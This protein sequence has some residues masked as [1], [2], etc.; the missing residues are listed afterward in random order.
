M[1]GYVV[2]AP[3]FGIVG[4]I[5]AALIYFY[6]KRQPSGTK[7]MIEIS[8]AIHEGAMVFLKKEYKIISIFIVFVFL[9]KVK[10]VN[11]FLIFKFFHPK[12]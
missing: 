10:D 8:E 4:L 12:I 11:I 2:Y 3:V 9:C 6:I 7:V 1:E 5:T